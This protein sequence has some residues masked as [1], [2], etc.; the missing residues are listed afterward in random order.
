MTKLTEDQI[1]A[2]AK[3]AQEEL[4][5]AATYERL[6]QIVSRVV[7][8]ME[9][10]APKPGSRPERLLI[11]CLSPDN[12]ANAEALSQGLQDTG[13]RIADRVERIMGGF[14]VML[15]LVDTAGAT[16]DLNVLRQRL[17]DAGAKTGVKIM[18]QPESLVS[19]ST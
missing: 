19:G 7:A 14:Q 13:C 5:E 10:D 11:I 8:Q 4:G 15:A 3:T 6:H 12:R 17:S 9:T 2:I 18:V 16:S 1:R